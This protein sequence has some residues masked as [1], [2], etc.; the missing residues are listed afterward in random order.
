MPW[1]RRRDK[2]RPKPGAKRKPVEGRGQFL[3]FGPGRHLGR[4]ECLGVC[5]HLGLGE[6]HDVQ[7]GLAGGEERLDRGIERRAP[8]LEHERDGPRGRAHDRHRPL[9]A[10]RQAPFDVGRVAE[11]RRHEYELGPGKLEEWHL[12]GPAPVGVAVEVELVHDHLVDRRLRA[13]AKRHVGDDLGRRAHERRR[14]VDRGVPGEHADVLGPEVVA[15]GEELLRDEG[16]YRCGVERAHAAGEGG[17]VGAEGDEA[18]AGAQSGVFTIT[19]APEK[20]SNS[21]SS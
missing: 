10:A 4:G 8:V 9:C 15:Q 14:G 12:P 5:Q 21:A 17:D 20:T 2:L 3:A 19:W 13:G 11:G 7:R 6:V 18:L 1:W 16:L